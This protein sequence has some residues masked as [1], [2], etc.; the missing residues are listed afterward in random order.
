MVSIASRIRDMFVLDIPIDRAFPVRQITDYNGRELNT[1][2]AKYTRWHQRFGHI[3][4]QIISKVHTAVDDIGQAVR[5]AEDQPIYEVCSL[6][7][8]IRVVNRVSPERST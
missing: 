3:G 7:K 8:K 4:P 5:P 6:T 2:R 1:T